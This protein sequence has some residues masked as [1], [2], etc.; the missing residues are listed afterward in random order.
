MTKSDT[1]LSFGLV[2]ASASAVTASISFWMWLEFMTGVL[3]TLVAAAIA[4]TDFE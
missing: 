4:G 2:I 3:V 1:L